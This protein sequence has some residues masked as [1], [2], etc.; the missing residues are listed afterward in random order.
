MSWLLVPLSLTMNALSGFYVILRE[1]DPGSNGN[2]TM[3]KNRFDLKL[4]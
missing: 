3:A 2:L 1:Q 4:A